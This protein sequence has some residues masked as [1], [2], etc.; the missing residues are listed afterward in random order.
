MAR[1]MA[2][3]ARWPRI[4]RMLKAAGHVWSHRQSIESSIE[5]AD[6]VVCKR[7]ILRRN[8]RIYPLRGSAPGT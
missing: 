7:Q 2:V 5:S 4:Y 8:S 3:Q 1:S 6:D